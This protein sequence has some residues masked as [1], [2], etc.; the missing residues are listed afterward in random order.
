MISTPRLGYF[1][2]G[3][4]AINHAEYKPED[5]DGE[6]NYLFIH[7]ITGRYETWLEVV[8]PIRSGNRAVAVDLRGHGRSGHTTGSYRLPDYARDVAEL[9][10]D[11]KLGPATV[12]GHSLGAMTAIQLAASEPSLVQA[13]ILEDPPLFA[14]HIMEDGGQ[15]R[16]ERFGNNAKLAGSGLTLQ[17]MEQQIRQALPEATDEVIRK[18]ALSLFVTDA[19]ALFHVYD[20]RIDWEPEIESV[21]Q[22]V[23]CPVLLM[24]GNFELGAWMREPDGAR[25]KNLF[26]DCTLEYWQDTGHS[27]H[28]EHPDR[29][30]EQVARFVSESILAAGTS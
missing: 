22:S 2:T 16:H 19:D 3:E 11:K 17:Q 30:V 24:Q 20:E 28:S 1:N 26:N 18:S 23:R 15:E 8:D 25:A 21:M 27:L 10:R 4:V 7:G 9:I 29:F 5:R 14:R 12:I 13:I 6:L